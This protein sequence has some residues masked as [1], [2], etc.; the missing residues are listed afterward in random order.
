M[1]N[2]GSENGSSVPMGT[3]KLKRETI[4]NWMGIAFN[5]VSGQHGILKHLIV[6]HRATIETIVGKHCPEVVTRCEDLQPLQRQ[7]DGY[8]SL[9]QGEANSRPEQEL[10]AHEQREYGSISERIQH[11]FA[12]QDQPMPVIERVEVVPKTGTMPIVKFK[13]I[14]EKHLGTL[15]SR[16]NSWSFEKEKLPEEEMQK[17]KNGISQLQIDWPTQ[18]IDNWIYIVHLHEQVENLLD[19]VDE[20]IISKLNSNNRVFHCF[21]LLARGRQAEAQLEAQRLSESEL[22]IVQQLLAVA[23]PSGNPRELRNIAQGTREAL[24]AGMNTIKTLLEGLRRGASDAVVELETFASQEYSLPTRGDIAEPMVWKSE[25]LE[26]MDE[27]FNNREEEDNRAIWFESDRL[28]GDTKS[29]WNRFTEGKHFKQYNKAEAEF[30]GN[31]R[32]IIQTVQPLIRKSDFDRLKQELT[33]VAK[34]YNEMIATRVNPYAG[35]G[36]AKVLMNR[37]DVICA[38]V[39]HKGEA[40]LWSTDIGRSIDEIDQQTMIEN[41]EPLSPQEI[42]H[43]LDPVM[44]RLQKIHAEEY[45]KLGRR[46]QSKGNVQSFKTLA[47]MCFR[48]MPQQIVSLEQ[49]FTIITVPVATNQAAYEMGQRERLHKGGSLNDLGNKLDE[50]SVALCAREY[51]RFTDVIRKR[52]WNVRRNLAARGKIL[53]PEEEAPTHR[54]GGYTLMNKER[55]MVELNKH[56]RS[57]QLQN[58]ATDLL[59][60]LEPDLQ[61]KVVVER[62]EAAERIEAIFEDQGNQVSHDE[63]LILK[64]HTIAEC[65]QLR[66]AVPDIAARDYLDLFEESYRCVFWHIENEMNSA[67]RFLGWNKQHELMAAVQGSQSRRAMTGPLEREFDLADLSNP[68]ASNSLYVANPDGFEEALHKYPIDTVVVSREIRRAFITLEKE[69]PLALSFGHVDDSARLIPLLAQC[70]DASLASVEGSENSIDTIAS[71]DQIFSRLGWIFDQVQYRFKGVM[72]GFLI[73]RFIALRKRLQEQ[74]LQLVAQEEM[75]QA[76]STTNHSRINAGQYEAFFIQFAQNVLTDRCRQFLYSCITPAMNT[77]QIGQIG[78]AI[79]TAVQTVMIFLTDRIRARCAQTRGPIS[80]VELQQCFAEA[81]QIDVAI[82]GLPLG[83]GERFRTQVLNFLAQDL[84]RITTPEGLIGAHGIPSATEDYSSLI[85]REISSAQRIRDRETL[86]PLRQTAREQHAQCLKYV[87]AIRSGLTELQMEVGED[88]AAGQRLHHLTQG[89]A[90]LR[91]SLYAPSEAQNVAGDEFNQAID[92]LKA[93]QTTLSNLYGQIQR[94]NEEV[95]VQRAA[96][97]TIRNLTDTL[98]GMLHFLYHK[99]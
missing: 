63:L 41:P 12:T 97:E 95:S 68:A 27:E 83:I 25:F 17:L 47:R 46:S 73:Q 22:S 34:K 20:M 42:Q 48:E 9:L 80:L 40:L 85:Q 13:G 94:T 23:S 74:T 59:G 28:K 36:V 7:I 18:A 72:H 93:L 62:D 71:F 43:V 4:Q 75:K 39:A 69:L 8:F 65:D 79:N 24:D 87:E 44:I 52:T 1:N 26:E 45:A 64:A 29:K 6:E 99:P 32:R 91:F 55:M 49:L 38:G 92:H 60:K 66:R 98:K 21:D 84:S 70:R 76:L 58:G 82:L 90:A 57:Y 61:D 81:A 53:S 50:I 51:R 35:K 14:W 77:E 88:D 56:L 54:E 2:K 11:L 16:I 96:I 5:S 78:G 37:F 15:L 10:I 86:I 30:I 31:V 67:A 33:V 19:E 89:L 3:K